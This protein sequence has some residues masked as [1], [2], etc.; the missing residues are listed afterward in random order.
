MTKVPMLLWC[1]AFA[2][3]P[4]ETKADTAAP[5]PTTPSEQDTELG[6]GAA[7]YCALLEPCFTTPEESENCVHDALNNSTDQCQVEWDGL[8]GCIAAE[9]GDNPLV[10]QGNGLQNYVEVL[11]GE[12]G[13]CTDAYD[14][15]TACIVDAG[16]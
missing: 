2:C 1:A 14:A 16:A 13:P 15:I 10:C 11:P 6:D 7:A 12:Y 8:L 4:E 3:G 9:L 5:D